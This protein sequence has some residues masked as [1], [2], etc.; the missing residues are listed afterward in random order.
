MQSG[1]SLKEL[2]RVYS[3]ADIFVLPSLEDVWGFVINEAMVCGLPVVSTRSSQAALEMVNSGENGYVVE[4]GDS[5][6]LYVALKNLIRN[7]TERQRMAI[8]SKEVAMN[9]FDVRHMVEGFISAIK[10]GVRAIGSVK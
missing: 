8:R 3:A 2:I 1:L 10:Y 5:M 9:R 6:E 7:P 4:A